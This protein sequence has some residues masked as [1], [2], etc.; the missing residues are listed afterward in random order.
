MATSE[1]EPRRMRGFETVQSQVR[2]YVREAALRPGDRLPPER[3]LARELGV[4][5]NSLR[6]SLMVLRVEGLI[7]IQHGSGAYLLRSIEDVIPPISA[8]LRIS[9]PLL[10]AV[11]EV[12]NALEAL[13]ARLAAIR[14]D[15]A[16]LEEMVASIRQMHAEILDG[17]N[18]LSGDRRFHTAVLDAAHNPILVEMLAAVGGG[19]EQIAAASLGRDDQPPR[20][21]AAH[22]LVFEAI[23]GR[24]AQLA[25]DT[26]FAH[27]D[28]TGEISSEPSPG[29]SGVTN[30]RTRGHT[31]G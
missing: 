22:R 7:D 15:D 13:A 6:E 10:P 21:L 28:R 31:A 14:R 9:D 11:G 5:R 2:D 27:L 4:S 30:L 25:H 1:S 19:A 3:Q 12:R 17:D 8:E 18:G 16:D 23:A 26:M 20:S 24:E 29:T